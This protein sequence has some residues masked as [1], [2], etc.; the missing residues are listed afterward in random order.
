M[1]N[2]QEVE[3]VR[4]SPRHSTRRGEVRTC[5]EAGNSKRCRESQQ[6]VNESD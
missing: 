4:T 3:E 2:T 6:R 5:G 1:R